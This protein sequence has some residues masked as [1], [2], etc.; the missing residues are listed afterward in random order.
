A[1]APPSSPP[2]PAAGPGLPPPPAHKIGGRP[3][4]AGTASE[5]LRSSY[6]ACTGTHPRSV[7][8]SADDRPPPAQTDGPQPCRGVLRVGARCSSPGSADEEDAPSLPIR[9]WLPVFPWRLVYSFPA[10]PARAGP[11]ALRRQLLSS[12]Q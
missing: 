6:Q 1:E 2:Q 8:A 7:S 4:G 12:S 3:R 5:T 10:L 11:M 9:P